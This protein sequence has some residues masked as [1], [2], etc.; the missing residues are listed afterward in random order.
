[1]SKRQQMSETLHSP[2]PK[3]KEKDIGPENTRR[4]AILRAAYEIFAKYGFKR[5]TM[6]DI[7]KEAGVSRPALYQLFANKRE[8][9]R[10][11][12]EAHITHVFIE[13]ETLLT[14]DKSDDGSSPQ[15]L[16]R[17]ILVTALIEPHRLLENMPHGEELLGI[18]TEIAGDLFQDWETRLQTIIH[19]ALI[20]SH[21][22][23]RTP[24]LTKVISL[25]ITG[26]KTRNL[27]ADQM[28]QEIE[29][30]IEIV[31]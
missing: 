3:P 16:I 7:A 28:D 9:F 11:I 26:L 10:K 2:K 23:D 31:G 24:A 25:A 8:I 22:S 5:T 13:L 30:L 27:S 12:V 1:M 17:A 18:K 4:E 29:S 20:K 14:A 15:S 19:R 21:P 6:D